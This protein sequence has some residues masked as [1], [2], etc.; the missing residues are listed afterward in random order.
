MRPSFVFLVTVVA[1]VLAA[2]AGCRAAD[3][4]RTFGN[5]RAGHPLRRRFP[6]PY[7]TTLTGTITTFFDREGN[8]TRFISHVL[9]QNTITTPDGQQLRDWETIN[10][11]YDSVAHP[12][13]SATTH[14][15]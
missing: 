8:P 2:P 9:W 1:L 7:S 11:T 4:E 5:G 12:K 6:F 3:E 15:S 13:T 14:C 10:V